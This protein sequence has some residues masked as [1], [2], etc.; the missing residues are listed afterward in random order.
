VREGVDDHLIELARETA[1]DLERRAV[2]DGLSRVNERDHLQSSC[3]SAARVLAATWTPPA[4]VSTG[5]RFRSELWPRLGGVDLVLLYP[6]EKPVAIELKCGS[7]RD[8]L[9]PCA[10]DALKL[11]FALQIGEA[12]AGYLLAATPA[13]DWALRF[14]GA[15]L[16]ETATVEALVLRERFLDWWRHW[17]RLGDPMPREVPGR[18]RT[19]TVGLVPFEV[20]GRA[21]ELR[22]AAISVEGRDRIAWLPTREPSAF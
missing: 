11:C 17:E 12:S 9:G 3:A 18:F 4:E 2:R 22:V 6:T 21:W 19:R 5:F 20:D 16:F 13:S 1:A 8:A 10:W 15:E 14:R 7:G